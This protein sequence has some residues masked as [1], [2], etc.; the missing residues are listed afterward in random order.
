MSDRRD[1]EK[2]KKLEAQQQVARALAAKAAFK[3]ATYFGWAKQAYEELDRLLAGDFSP[4]F[5]NRSEVL[6]IEKKGTKVVGGLLWHARNSP[7]P[8]ARK[9]AVLTALA[10]IQGAL[11]YAEIVN[12]CHDLH[13]AIALYLNRLGCPAVVVRG[14][15]EA[16]AP[17]TR[18]FIM[19]TAL[20]A[21]KPGYKTGH[22]WI[23][24]PFW[25]VVDLSLAHQSGVGDDHEA[26]KSKIPSTILIETREN[27]EP[28]LR[29]VKTF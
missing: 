12:Q 1:R 10:R 28:K 17:G 5:F 15:L 8:E 22:S 18:G 27:S 25:Y 23:V 4:C 9:P 7:R 11:V 21:A 2:K 26:L 19:S 24:T 16:S 6:A 14:T 29:R 20:D 3:R 13:A